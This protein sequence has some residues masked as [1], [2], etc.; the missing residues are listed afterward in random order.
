VVTARIWEGGAVGAALLT[1]YYLMV[2]P[3]RRERRLTIDGMLLIGWG[4]MWASEDSWL[5]YSRPVL[6]YNSVFFNLGCPQCKLPGF[7]APH[8]DRMTEPLIWLGSTYVGVCFV[9]TLGCC[10]V[11]RW[12]KRRWPQLGTVGLIGVALVT[13]FGVDAVLESIFLRFGLISY[14]SAVRWMSLFPGH[15]YQYPIY[16]GVTFG[17]V[18]ALSAC[19]RYFKNDRGEILAER[20][21]EQL[22]ASSR[23]KTWIRLLAVCGALCTIYFVAYEMPIQWFATHSDNYPA[24][25]LQ[26]SYLTNMMC[27]PGTDTACPGPRVPMPVGA[28]SARLRP[29]GTL[30]SPKGVPS[31]KGGHAP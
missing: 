29:D 7:Q 2:R 21:I 9:L 25:V 15:Y 13:M 17:A 4:L 26:R 11:M 31:Q 24:E 12:A 27:G 5:N 28:D 1:I 23:Q 30:Y 3:W 18:M 20:G 10:W 8:A 14:P 19:L 6:S 22:H 16:E